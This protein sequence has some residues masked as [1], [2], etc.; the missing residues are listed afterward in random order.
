MVSRL[1]NV[2]VQYVDTLDKMPIHSM[3][4]LR[5]L[6]VLLN[7]VIDRVKRVTAAWRVLVGV[8]APKKW[9]L[10][11]SALSQYTTPQTPPENPWIDRP[12]TTS[13][14]TSGLVEASTNDT[15]NHARRRPPSR[16]IMRHLLRARANA[17]KALA[18]F[19]DQLEKDQTGKR[20]RTGTRLARLYG[21]TDAESDGWR[22]VREVI[23]FLKARGARIPT[24]EGNIKGWAADEYSTTEEP[25]LEAS[26]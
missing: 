7:S 1:L 6:T 8:W 24:G 5:Y 2:S 22:Y 26:R 3:Q 10:S 17:V 4:V 19:F 12:R 23:G 18:S 9:D 11:L 16:R 14:S 21:F 20:V 25:E 15:R 13:L